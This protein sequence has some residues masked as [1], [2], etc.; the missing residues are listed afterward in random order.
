MAEEALEEAVVGTGEVIVATDVIA[1]ATE[2]EIVTAV[3]A[4]AETDT[5]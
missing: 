3:T 4:E 5:G 2:T 1:E